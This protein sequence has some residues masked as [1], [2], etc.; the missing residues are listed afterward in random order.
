MSQDLFDMDS[1]P[2]LKGLR[3]WRAQMIVGG[4]YCT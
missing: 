2:W 3:K 4:R 1:F